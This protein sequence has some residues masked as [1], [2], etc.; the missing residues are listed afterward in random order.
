MLSRALKYISL[1]VCVWW[2]HIKKDFYKPQ[3]KVGCTDSHNLAYI[4]VYGEK[5]GLF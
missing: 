3:W 1:Y 2:T 4:F 5:K